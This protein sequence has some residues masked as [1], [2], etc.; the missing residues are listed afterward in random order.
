MV[1]DADKKMAVFA[2]SHC[3]TARILPDVTGSFSLSD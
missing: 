1:P 2:K 3:C